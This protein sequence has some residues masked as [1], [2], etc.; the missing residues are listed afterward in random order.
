[1]SAPG[2]ANRPLPW[3]PGSTPLM[4]A[5]MQGLT[6]RALR[7]WFCEEVRPDT[8]FT[9]FLRVK[10]NGLARGDRR[11]IVAPPVGVPLV[12]QLVGHQAAGLAAAVG[13]P[14]QAAAATHKMKIWLPKSRKK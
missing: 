14:H 8:V 1:M 3:A 6:N 9:E 4:L 7:G 2:L 12:V 5:P 10:G 13:A 11:E